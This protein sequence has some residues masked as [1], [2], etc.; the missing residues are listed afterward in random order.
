M[1]VPKAKSCSPLLL[2]FCWKPDSFSGTTCALAASL[3]GTRTSISCFQTWTQG[4][5]RHPPGHHEHLG[6][7]CSQVHQPFSVTT[8]AEMTLLERSTTWRSGLPCEGP[9]RWS[10]SAPRTETWASIDASRVL[11]THEISPSCSQPVSPSGNMVSL[12]SD[13]TSVAKEAPY[14]ESG[15]KDNA[16]CRKPMLAGS[17]SKNN[18]PDISLAT[19]SHLGLEPELLWSDH[20]LVTESRG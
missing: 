11:Y 6:C 14:C 17:A 1:R 15:K 20:L 7:Q 12:D 13:L 4:L 2:T 16:N 18:P 10:W 9:T 3:P 19:N 5:D 8:A